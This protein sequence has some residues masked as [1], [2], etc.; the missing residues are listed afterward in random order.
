MIEVNVTI[1]VERAPAEV[2]AFWSD[3]SN[4][5]RWQKGMR[6]CT[7]TSEPPLGVGS[8]YDQ[9]AS[10]LGRAIISSFECVEYEPDTM[11]RMKTTNSSLPLDITRAV[12]PGPGGG[13]ILNATIG[14]D[15]QGL[16]RLFNPLTKRMVARS[17][18]QDYRRLKE[19]LDVDA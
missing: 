14:G 17:V 5:P 9:E 19:L 12:A 10:F 2:F 3:H 13:T 15:P 1:E 6:R 4:N 7:W 8:T 11:I 18:N 16:M